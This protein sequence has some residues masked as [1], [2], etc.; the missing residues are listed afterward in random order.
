MYEKILKAIICAQLDILLVALVRIPLL[1]HTIRNTLANHLES[2][3]LRACSNE[4]ILE[5]FIEQLSC[6]LS[7]LRFG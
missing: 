7:F 4:Y 3:C 1:I 6:R 5:Y 2:V